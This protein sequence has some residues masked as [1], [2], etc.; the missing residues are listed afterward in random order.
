MQGTG[1]T[2]VE[3]R[4]EAWAGFRTPRLRSSDS[5]PIVLGRE[6]GMEGGG[7]WEMLKLFCYLGAGFTL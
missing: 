2:A 7:L 6:H 3:V 1:G 4:Q 5:G